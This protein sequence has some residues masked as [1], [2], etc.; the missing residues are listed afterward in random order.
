MAKKE[1]KACLECGGKIIGRADK[2][3]CSDQCRVSY[4]NKLNR[5][6]TAYMN[7]VTNILRKNRRILLDLNTTGKTKV[8]R[9][10][11][12]EKGF[13]FTYFTSQY[14]T[15]EGAIYHFCYEQGYLAMDK[16]WYLLVV[17]KETAKQQPL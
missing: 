1:E 4:N 8:N 7:N 11:L 15:K 5:D 14:V 3:F 6:E 16:N 17:K 12:N 10:K 2:K 13:D 9:D